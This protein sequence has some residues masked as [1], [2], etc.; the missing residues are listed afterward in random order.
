MTGGHAETDVVTKSKKELPKTVTPRIRDRRCNAYLH[1]TEKGE[2]VKMKSIQMI[3]I[4]LL[5][6]HPQN[7]RKRIGDV[8]ELADSI[9]A[10]GIMQNLTVVPFGD[11]YRI[12]IGHR[13]WTAAKEAGM[14]E[15]PCAIVD[16][17]EKDQVEIMLV[18]NMQRSD[19][20]VLEESQGLQLMVEMG[21]SIRDICEKTGFS[22]SK[23]RHR[24]KM[25]E[26]DQKVLQK[27]F[28]ECQNISILDLQKL[29]KIKD[30]A[31]KDR[32]L[33]TIGTSNFEMALKKAV[34]E[35]KRAEWEEEIIATLPEGT[36]MI[37][38]NEGKTWF[39]SIRD[40]MNND[41]SL[42]KIKDY[43]GKLY[44]KR[45][46]NAIEIY[47]DTPEEAIRE[48]EERR[49]R[50]RLLEERMYAM[51]IVLR[52]M[53]M[54]RE[55]FVTELSNRDCGYLAFHDGRMQ[56]YMIRTMNEGCQEPEKLLKLLDIRIEEAPPSWNKEAWET[57]LHENINDTNFKRAVFLMMYLHVEPNYGN[58]FDHEG[59]FKP[60]NT[61]KDTYEFMKL[62]GYRMSNEEKAVLDGSHEL[63]VK[64]GE[65]E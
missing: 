47:I 35:E 33:T 5:E 27:K 37:T 39:C 42:Q 24:V 38:S 61:L 41:A 26:L 10:V 12:L 58:P 17:P 14:K 49:E 7:P 63:Y 16:I 29:E 1:Y 18:E 11:K 31:R 28:E 51:K 43:D 20:T 40:W 65:D 6:A 46:Y 53:E 59:K 4:N 44:W 22:E 15:L 56:K 55:A 64:E 25:G 54:L 57:I 34:D 36:K 21:N 9:K 19:L 52:N 2:K 60:E 45:G 8:T 3:D 32:V 48:V 62:I 50:K 30:P 23:V 13:R